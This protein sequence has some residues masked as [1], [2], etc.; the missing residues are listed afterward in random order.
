MIKAIGQNTMLVGALAV[1]ATVTGMTAPLMMSPR[2]GLGPGLVQADSTGRALVAVGVSL[3]V[4]TALAVA[5]GRVCNTVVGLFVLGG[6]LFGLAW[7]METIHEIGFGNSLVGVAVETIVWSFV[8]VAATWAVF[9]LA[10]P[11]RDIAP[12]EHGLVPDPIRSRSALR[13]AAA[14]LLVLP[15]VWVVAQ[16]PVKGQV[17]GAVFCG[18]MAAGLAGRLLAPHVQPILLFATPVLFGGLGQ[19]AAALL[20]REPLRAASVA[21][22]IGPLSR[23]MPLDY[24]VGSLMGVAVGVGWARSFLHHE[25]VHAPGAPGASPAP[26]PSAPSRP[27]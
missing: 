4:A 22:T 24:V 25:E 19:L 5:V 27:A 14:G 16:T 15:V 8:V 17:I 18:G 13:S 23:P 2:G 12:D 11:L 7:R 1:G 21:D 3:V 20:L 6:S 26:A 9:R 10:G